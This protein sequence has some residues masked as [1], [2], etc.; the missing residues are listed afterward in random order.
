MKKD[1]LKAYRL[2][3]GF[4][5]IRFKEELFQVLREISPRAKQLILEDMENW[6]LEE[7][8]LGIKS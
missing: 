5:N 3:F 4:T 2:A 8:P 7:N 6:R 1:L